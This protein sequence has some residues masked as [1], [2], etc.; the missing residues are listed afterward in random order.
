MTQKHGGRLI[1]FNV[2]F[3]ETIKIGGIDAKLQN[4]EVTPDTLPQTIK[5]DEGFDGIREIT[6]EKDEELRP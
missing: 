2:N 4:K 6:I 1:M 5:P 3:D